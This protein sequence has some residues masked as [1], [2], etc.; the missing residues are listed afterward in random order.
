MGQT[1]DTVK[2]ERENIY[3]EFIRRFRSD[4]VLLARSGQGQ[5]GTDGISVVPSGTSSH[6]PSISNNKLNTSFCRKP[7]NMK[8]T[9]RLAR[10]SLIASDALSLGLAYF[11]G[12]GV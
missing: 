1:H 6:V 2:M 10:V 5:D 11:P 9:L 12:S 4:C 3:T 7:S 8:Q